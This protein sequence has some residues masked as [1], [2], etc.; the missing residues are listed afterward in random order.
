MHVSG[1]ATGQLAIAIMNDVYR[2]SNLSN[3]Y[4]ARSLA[5]AAVYL[6]LRCLKMDL[7][8]EFD[9]VHIKKP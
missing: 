1:K 3:K 5:S 4:S 9:K 7:P 6:S 8:T 2:L